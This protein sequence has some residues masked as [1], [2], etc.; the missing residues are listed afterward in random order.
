MHFKYRRN[1]EVFLSGFKVYK[2]ALKLW[3]E[4]ES[5]PSLFCAQNVNLFLSI[6]AKEFLLKIIKSI[7]NKIINKAQ[8]NKQRSQSIFYYI[9]NELT[10]FNL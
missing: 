10:D 8:A 4:I 9:Q 1:K 5:L 6:I 3:E 2:K 7:I